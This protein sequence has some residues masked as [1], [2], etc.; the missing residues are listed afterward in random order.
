MPNRPDCLSYFGIATEIQ[1]L[2]GIAL[3]ITPA[4][5]I[6]KAKGGNIKVTNE[7]VKECLRYCGREMSNIK[8]AE[9]SH[10]IKASLIANGLQP[11]NNIV[12]AANYIML[13]TGQPL[14]V[15]DADKIEGK[16]IVIRHAKKGEEINALDENK[17]KLDENILV[18]ADQKKPLAIAGIKGGQ[19]AAI[20]KH[21]KRIF[22]ESANFE[23]KGIRKS[24]RKL[25]LKTDASIRYEYGIDRNMCLDALN[26]FCSLIEGDIAKE[27]VDIYP[28]VNRIKPKTIKFN[29]D[30]IEKIIGLSIPLNQV[31]SILKSL[32]IKIVKKTSKALELS[33]PTNR[34]DLNI[35]ADIAEELI[36]IYGLN[37]VKS[38]LP[39]YPLTIPKRNEA[40][41]WE[42]NIKNIL[43]ELGF[44][45]TYNY[46][47]ISDKDAKGI[48]NLIELENP[49]SDEFKYLRPNLIF[50]LL[51]LVGFNLKIKQIQGKKVGDYLQ[52]FEIG[53]I[54]KKVKSGIEEKR[55]L[56]GLIWS[57]KE[58]N[59]FLCA[60]SLLE[61][62]F[63]QLGVSSYY[64]DPDQNSSTD[65]W[66]K[67]KTAEINIDGKTVGHLGAISLKILQDFES[68]QW[69]FA[70]DI[71]LEKLIKECNEENEF[72]EIP[73][74][75]AAI[76]DISILL[77]K[78][79]RVA[80]VLK[81][82]ND[83]S[84]NLKDADLLDIYEGKEL[85][86]GKKNLTFRLIFQAKDRTLFGQ[87]IDLN[88]QKIIKELEKNPGWEVRK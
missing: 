13:E 36:R 35:P 10:W 14:H 78:E 60:K 3:N 42:N 40:V 57:E 73:K 44:I 48:G 74:F 70:F 5:I 27:I 64:F 75:P 54:F 47:F 17:Y 81:L 80:A 19:D 76:R 2:T 4:K 18:I 50:N 9:S 77:P 38:N 59:G 79:I 34:P 71:D 20:S 46:S 49:V 30:L 62:L 26:R 86:E 29:L 28:G 67:S 69:V 7:E 56:T 12:D 25:N 1:A 33:I 87:E 84:D 41:Y 24:S 15:F 11:I 72:E 23:Y 16:Q 83:V 37:R 82:L 32:N 88:M 63:K 66:I 85:P 39:I 21:T 45:E 51:K 52:L 61:M 58:K 8:V 22:I 53:N 65:V 68:P 6:A 43:K 55:M 31:V